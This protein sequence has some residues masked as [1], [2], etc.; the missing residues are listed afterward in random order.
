[1]AK[2]FALNRAEEEQAAR[3]Q[4]E[5]AVK[6]V[7]AELDRKQAAPAPVAVGGPPPD[8]LKGTVEMQHALDEAKKRAEDAE[9]AIEDVRE[10]L[11]KEK[12]AKNAAWKVVSQLTKQLKSAK[13]SA[14][15]DA[16]SDDAAAAAK[17]AKPRPK[18]KSDAD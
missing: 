16:G 3:E 12:A 13:G 11:A 17:K 15:Q 18:K 4:A 14:P 5:L 8:A 10:Q 2:D 1:M 7:R 9:S 6:E